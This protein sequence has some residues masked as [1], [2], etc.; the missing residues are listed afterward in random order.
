MLQRVDTK[1]LFFLLVVLKWYFC[2]SIVPDLKNI[3]YTAG[4][5]YGGDTE[6]QFMWQRFENA[7]VPSE[8]QK[9]LNALATTTD[10]GT[11][12]RS[13]LMGHDYCNPYYFWGTVA[14]WLEHW[15]QSRESGFKSSCCNFETWEI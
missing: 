1:W 14:G 7:T 12:Q 9:L 2:N 5:R 4:V 13:V 10:A 3:V 8:Q 11:I 15:T 6:W